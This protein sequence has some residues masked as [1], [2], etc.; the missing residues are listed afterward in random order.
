MQCSVCGVENPEHANFCLKCG[1]AL[2]VPHT[3][4][5]EA[6]PP[7]YYSASP[8]KL[9]LLGSLSFGLYWVWWFWSQCRSEDPNEG[10]SWTLFRTILS[11]FFFYGMAREVQEEAFRRE[12]KCWC[13]PV[14]LTGLYGLA[15]SRRG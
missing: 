7:F 15:V 8:H 13:S 9:Y 2:G 5:T 1:S 10:R 12:V 6:A 11:G 14:I 4:I 3:V